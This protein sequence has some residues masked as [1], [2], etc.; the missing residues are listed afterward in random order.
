ME[1]ESLDKLGEECGIFSIVTHPEAARIAY[2]G[3]YALQHRGQES[4]GIVTS[5]W[6][7]LYLERGMGYVADLFNQDRLEKLPGDSAL[8]HVR[9]STSGESA[10]W[11][12][13]PILIDCWRGQIA[14][15]HNGNLTNAAQLRR[16]LER[17]GAIFH[18]TS[19][20]EVVLH[21][22]SRSRRRTLQEA[23]VEAL[24]M[25]QGAY[26]MVLMTPEYIL[27]ARDP[28][29]FRPLVLGR[30]KESYVVTSET[31]ALDLINAEY[32]REIEPGEVTL[33]EGNSLESQFPLPKEKPS[34]CIFEHIYFSRPDSLV[35]G[36]TV[37]TSRHEMGRNLAREHPVAAD[38]IVP[39]PDSGVSASI[40]YAK[41]SGLPLEFGLIRNH[42]VGRTFIEPKQAI[43]N[44]GVKI[45]LNPVREILQGRR[46]VL[47]DDS[48]VRGT[49]SKKIVQIIR[50]AG[51]REVH[52]RITAPPLIAPCYYGI[53][54][55]TRRELIASSKTVDE[56]CEFLGADSLGYMSIENLMKSLGN[57]NQYCSACFSDKYPTDVIFEDKQRKLFKDSEDLPFTEAEVK[58]QYS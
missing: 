31:C 46:V 58:D 5:D 17:D 23:F 20:S 43:R 19:D 15:A 29:G 25:I 49:T 35:F 16:E 45:K 9:Y 14:L 54:I 3:L 37:N 52:V 33:I 4:A 56:I 8:G 34:F 32:I 1:M 57:K 44:F 55:P 18:S 40:G 2:L 12:A 51:V 22:I 48:I 10:S 27:A 21:L 50:A 26:S 42:Y 6:N 47:V 39:V 41:E 24:R 28:H 53:D 7:K 36:R 30:I 38:V 11:N 13:Q